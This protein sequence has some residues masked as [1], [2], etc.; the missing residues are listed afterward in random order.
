M[1]CENVRNRI[2]LLLDHRIDGGERDTMVAHLA[3]C[4]ACGARFESLRDMK[5]VMGKMSQTPV[6]ANVQAKLRALAAHE[7]AR[8]LT[9]LSRGSRISYWSGRLYMEFENLM[10]PI[11]LPFAGGV[12]AALLAFAMLVPNLSFAHHLFN[13]D[14]AVG[15]PT[16]P[17]GKV[18]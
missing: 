12:F 10:R 7:R 17:D 13:D 4:D 3:S 18:V 1:S 2:S 5:R 16:N 14:P 8:Q 6:P 11:A 9:R 15:F